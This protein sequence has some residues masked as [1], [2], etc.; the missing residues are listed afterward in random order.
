MPQGSIY[1]AVGRLSVLEKSALD[2]PRLER[3]LQAR[4][5]SQALR[6]LGEVGWREDLHFEQAAGEHLLGACRL[7]RDLSTNPAMV[8]AFLIRYDIANLKILLKA[9]TLGE[10]PGALSACGVFSPDVLRHA[11]NEHRYDAL[12]PVLKTALDGL[13][14]KM[15]V[16]V[17]PMDIDVTLDKAH[18]AWAFDRLGKSG[19]A[20]ASWLRDRV[21][22]TNYAMLLRAMHAGKPLSFVS[23]MLIPGG[24]VSLAAWEKDYTRPEKLP[25]HMNRFG[26]QLYASAVAAHLNPNKLAVYE[27]DADNYL[28]G[29]FTPYRRSIDQ[30]E[31]LIG[32]LMMR[33]R[34][35]AAVRLILAGKENGFAEETIRERLRALYG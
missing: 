20:S 35:A 26:T 9:R 7:V 23:P 22:L 13:E 1:Y 4:D 18:Y 11:V 14:R 34:E 30:E 27:R 17:D 16:S 6:V 31:R 19:G 24:R 25:L 12:G 5:T 33:E 10:E 28:M 29:L 21:D 2:A 15:A 3:L 32:Y 8:D